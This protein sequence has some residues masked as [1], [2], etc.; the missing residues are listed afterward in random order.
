MLYHG[1]QHI[2]VNGMNPATGSLQS[3]IPQIEVTER[4]GASKLVTVT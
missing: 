2:A 4:M 3:G 1:G